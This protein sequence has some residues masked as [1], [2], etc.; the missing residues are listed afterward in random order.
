MR[1]VIIG[2]C[3]R[4]NRLMN[5]ELEYQIYKRFDILERIG[6]GAYGVVF[7]VVDR[8]N[9]EVGALKKIC[10]AFQNRTDSQRTYREILYLSEVVHPNVV[11]LL[12]VI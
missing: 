9:G 1:V 10:D 2:R 3:Y 8:R 4:S 12:D 6:S 11:K 7:K 5:E